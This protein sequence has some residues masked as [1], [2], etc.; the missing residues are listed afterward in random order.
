MEEFGGTRMLE[1]IDSLAIG[2]IKLPDSI[3][4]TFPF[5]NDLRPA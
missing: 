1:V 2:P 5:N 4:L 3:S